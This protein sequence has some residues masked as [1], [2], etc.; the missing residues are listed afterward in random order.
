MTKTVWIVG[1]GAIGSAVAGKLR[2]GHRCVVVD[3]WPDHVAAIRASGLTVDY[4]EGSTRTEPPAYLAT[5]IGD[6][7]DPPNVIL[8]TEKAYHTSER[9]TAFRSRMSDDCFV[10]SLQ[11][12]VN[13]ELIAG[14]V[15]Q[16]RTVGAVVDFAAELL[17]PGRARA[18]GLDY[19]MLVGELDGAFTPRLASL[20][21]MIDPS[22][23]VAPTRV[24]WGALWS[25][26]VVNAQLNGLCAL[27]GLPTDEMAA[28]PVL[29]RLSLAL[30]VEAVRV[31]TKLSISL[32]PALLDGP[33]SDYLD[34]SLGRDAL[35]DL[36]TAFRE[37][38]DG[39][40]FTPS[41]LQDVEKKRPTEIDALNG[42]VV[43][44]GHKVGVAVPI[45]EEVVALVRAGE[46]R[47][48][49]VFEKLKDLHASLAD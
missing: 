45:N 24:I 10:V 37:R 23:P 17:G 22:I 43:D 25:K 49:A 38:W 15:G 1:V 19:G 16:E 36:E 33:L 41:M 20:T 26:L 2:P 4:P 31:A 21:E 13:E 14:L 48:S 44:K 32:D 42:Y 39:E 9:V 27:T 46:S 8:L 40:S 5:E 34:E 47:S 35:G 18:H 29:R 11:N 30:A 28:D 6:I 12:G 7:P 3:S